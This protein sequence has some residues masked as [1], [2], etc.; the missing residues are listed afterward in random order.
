MVTRVLVL[1][2]LSA[3]PAAAQIV[4]RPTDAPMVT[5]NN[6]SWYLLGEPIQFA[7]DVYYPA[8]PEVFFD[9]NV[10]ARSG[11]YNGV[12]LYMDTT[13]EPYSIVLVPVSRGLMQ[14]YERRRQGDLVGT[15]GSRTPAFPVRI[16]PVPGRGILQAPSAPSELPVPIG[17]SSAYTPEPGTVVLESNEPIERPFVGQP[18]T[19]ENLGADTSRPSA[20]TP[21]VLTSALLRRPENNDGIWIQFRD[22]KWVSAGKAVPLRSSEFRKIGEYDGFPV[23]ART[24]GDEL[25]YLPTRGGL[26]APYRRK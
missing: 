3:A 11:H 4:M 19:A 26:I 12:P 10:M 18:A 17:A 2:L 16:A 15:T 1:V 21:P 20:A 5:A 8:G 7:G 6:E 22:Q 9:G 13:V 25:I 24:G 23:F 14:P